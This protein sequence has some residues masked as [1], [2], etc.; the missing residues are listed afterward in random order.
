MTNI[1]KK[2]SEQ[3]GLEQE[4]PRMQRFRPRQSGPR[5]TVDAAERQGRIVRLAFASFGGRDGAIAFLNARHETLGGRPV[6]LAVASETG[7]AAVERAIE[8]HTANP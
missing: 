3:T 1:Q 6:E 7:C 2:K 8:E 4:G 5:L